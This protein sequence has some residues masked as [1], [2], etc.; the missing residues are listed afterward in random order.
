M[1]EVGKIPLIKSL[2]AETGTT[3]NREGLKPNYEP[4]LHQRLGSVDSPTGLF[5]FGVEWATIL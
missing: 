3:G 4:E 1:G 2:D 5:D